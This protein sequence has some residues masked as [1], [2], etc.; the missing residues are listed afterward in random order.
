MSE[1]LSERA[2]R[3]GGFWMAEFAPEIAALEQQLAAKDA[4]IARIRLPRWI[5]VADQEPPECKEVLLYGPEHGV[6]T[7]HLNTGAPPDGDWWI[8]GEWQSGVTHWAALPSPPAAL[9]ETPDAPLTALALPE[10]DVPD[11]APAALAS[12][13]ASAEQAFITNMRKGNSH[14]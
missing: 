13:K 11:A 4:E 6:V 1:K 5:A 8:R 3:I 2:A 9:A 14:D 10:D 7:G 12:E